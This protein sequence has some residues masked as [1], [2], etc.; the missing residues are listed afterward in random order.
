[1]PSD[2]LFK[3]GIASAIHAPLG[4]VL[5]SVRKFFLIS[6]KDKNY[7]VLATYLYL[8]HLNNYHLNVGEER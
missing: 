3:V 1:M 8:I 7:L 2:L 5:N 4:I 6:Q